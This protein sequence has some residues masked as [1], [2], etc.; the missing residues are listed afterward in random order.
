MEQ[1]NN[2]YY[3]ITPPANL[4]K[5]TLKYIIKMDS[6]NELKEIDIENSMC[7]YF[8]DIIEF[9]DFDLDNIQ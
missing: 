8:N 6:H 1:N 3:H 7:Y 9:E 2:V 5:L 4:E